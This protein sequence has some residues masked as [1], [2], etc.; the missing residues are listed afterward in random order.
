MTNKKIN[1]FFLFFCY[2]YLYVICI[3]MLF[4]YCLHLIDCRLLVD[5][6]F[7]N[8][9]CAIIRNFFAIKQNIHIYYFR[10]V[11]L[12]SEQLGDVFIVSASNAIMLL[13][14]IPTYPPHRLNN[15]FLRQIHIF[16][17]ISM[18]KLIICP[19]NVIT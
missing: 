2:L 5:C 12:R 14:I 9:I 7:F 1:N 16:T 13:Y 15:L 17:N 18:S 6:L 8:I 10:L 19:I 4:I 3:C 11:N